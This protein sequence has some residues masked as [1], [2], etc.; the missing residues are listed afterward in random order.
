MEQ[1]TVMDLYF[2][3]IIEIIGEIRATER[4]AILHAARIIA[5]HVEKDKILYVFGPGGHSN[6]AAM[7]IFFRAGGLMHVSAMLNQETMLSA[8]AMKSMQ[9]E[10]LPG[11]GKIIVEDYSIGT[12]D[13]LLVCNAYGIN[14]ATIDAAITAKERGATVIGI[15]SHEH[16]NNCP[17]NH[18]ARHPSKMNLHDIVDCSVDCKVKL[19][20]AIIEI[21]NLPQKIGALSTFANAYV[22]NSI[23]IEAINMLVS[24]GINPPIW[25]SGNCPGG[26]EWNTQFV[27][28]FRDRIRCL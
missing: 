19:G 22:L 13:L 8:G 21:E 17:K 4:G 28:Q 23:I 6:L 16:A 3:K 2:D 11:Y 1:G 12:G 25:R 15:S 9:V 14:S 20:D 10:R 5:G 7:E 26:D 27:G 18:P 24:A